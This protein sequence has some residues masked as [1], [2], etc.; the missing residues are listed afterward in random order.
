MVA[1]VELT[2]VARSVGEERGTRRAASGRMSSAT[3]FE[4]ILGGKKQHFLKFRP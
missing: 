1:G 2:I 3:V 4:T